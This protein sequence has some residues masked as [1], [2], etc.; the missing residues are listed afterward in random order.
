MESKIVNISILSWKSSHYQIPWNVGH[1]VFL[2][3]IV[4]EMDDTGIEAQT[5]L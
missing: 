1:F 2:Q 5:Q 3:D 4:Q